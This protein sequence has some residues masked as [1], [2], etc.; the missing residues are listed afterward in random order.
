MIQ[1]HP[2]DDLLLA[3]AAG[4]LAS[5]PALLASVHLESCAH[6]RARLHTLQALGGAMLQAQEPQ[7]LAPDALA[8]TLERIDQPERPAPQPAP[9][10]QAWPAPTLP[11]GA[12]W[13]RSLRGC[14][15]SRWR[16]MAP[17]MHFARVALPHEPEASLYLLQIAPGKSLAR[18][19][20]TGME[21]TQVLCGTF[22]DGRSVFG[23]G[24]F[25]EA[26][27]E[28][29]HQP[30]VTPGGVCVCLAYVGGRLKFDGRIA[31]AIGSLIG[32]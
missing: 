6:C 26:D 17:G 7:L 32:M 18:H 14:D 3:L 21:L 20:H 16:W 12:P 4:R 24:D 23:A 8:R 22:D 19:T 10:A 5:G 27:G 29:H 25:D 11:D 28:V 13:P 2:D 9:A 30:V 31:A 15:I 1:H